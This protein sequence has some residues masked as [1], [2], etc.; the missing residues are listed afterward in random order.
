MA[1]SDDDEYAAA[2]NAR[3]LR[4]AVKRGTIAAVQ[5]KPLAVG[6]HL[7]ANTS[8]VGCNGLLTQRPSESTGA[9]HQ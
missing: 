9:H 1:Q 5:M 3:R 4:D 6:S 2:E 8:R 7:A